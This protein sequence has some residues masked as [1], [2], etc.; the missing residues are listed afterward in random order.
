MR[1]SADLKH[2]KAIISISPSFLPSRDFT[3]RGTNN[4]KIDFLYF[5]YSP[6]TDWTFEY[7]SIWIIFFEKREKCRIS[8]S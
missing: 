1:I 3:F 7:E 5:F 6:V 2:V 4:M 8:M